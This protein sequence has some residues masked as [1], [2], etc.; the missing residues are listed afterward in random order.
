[1]P[2]L[3]AALSKIARARSNNILSDNLFVAPSA[4][5]A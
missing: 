1:M 3:N 5:S 2:A 4:P